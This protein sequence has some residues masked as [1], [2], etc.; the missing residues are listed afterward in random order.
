MELSS[1]ERPP[2][3]PPGGATGGGE[4]NTGGGGGGGGKPEG[5]GVG[6]EGHV[7]GELAPEPELLLF[8]TETSSS[9]SKA[10]CRDFFRA[11][12]FLLFFSSSEPW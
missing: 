2:D 8:L 3:E 4:F 6:D 1:A 12:I 5:G 7:G 10:D 11:R 9:F